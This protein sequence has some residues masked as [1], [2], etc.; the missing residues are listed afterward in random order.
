MTGRIRWAGAK[1][2]G[3]L[4]GTAALA[5]AL[6]VT[7]VGCGTS[8]GP[9]AS[10]PSTSAVSPPGQE[11]PAGLVVDITI[12]DGTAAPTNAELQGRVGEPITL[13]VSSD[14]TD[15]LHVHAIPERTFTVEP[16]AGQSFQF[17]VEV[18]G[19]VEVELHDLRRTVVT[20]QVQP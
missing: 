2:L 12:A 7:G 14:A 4:V 10:A 19:R 20:I 5:V 6:V 18:P 11:Q 8:A 9:G 17:S 1:R 13:R 3:D 15:E 16:R